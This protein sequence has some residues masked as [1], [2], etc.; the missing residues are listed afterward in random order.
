MSPDL[1]VQVDDELE[2]VDELEL[3]DVVELLLSFKTCPT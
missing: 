2:L 3:D 1:T